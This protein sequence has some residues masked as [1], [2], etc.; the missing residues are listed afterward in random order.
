MEFS[1]DNSKQKIHDALIEIVANRTTDQPELRDVVYPVIDKILD[2]A[3]EYDSIE[4]LENHLVTSINAKL[5][6][7]EIEARL[8][9]DIEES[10]EEMVKSGDVVKTQNAAGVPMYQ[11]ASWHL[12]NKL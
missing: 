7:A 12:K 4:A 11:L 8:I 9:K 10:L 1:S 3:E 2:C 6:E 5:V